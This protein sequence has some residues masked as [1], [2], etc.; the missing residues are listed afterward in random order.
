MAASGTREDLMHNDSV[1]QIILGYKSP[2]HC[3]PHPR[4]PEQNV[5]GG[6]FWRFVRHC[7]RRVWAL[8]ALR[9]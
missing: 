3:P 5:S 9:S 4:P 1:M 8:A 7:A 6:G 2:L